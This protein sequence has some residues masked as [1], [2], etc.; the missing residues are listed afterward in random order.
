LDRE[1]L[2]LTDIVINL[3]IFNA[4]DH[5][6]SVEADFIEQDLKIFDGCDDQGKTNNS[7]Q[8]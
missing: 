5:H 3:T 8:A 1:Y 4:D 2:Q 6:E 7:N